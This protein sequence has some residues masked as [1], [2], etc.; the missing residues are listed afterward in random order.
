MLDL[1]GG[2]V[3]LVQILQPDWD[4]DTLRAVRESLASGITVILKR[5][6]NGAST[7]H[8]A[9]REQAQLRMSQDGQTHVLAA[10]AWDAALAGVAPDIAAQFEAG[11]RRAGCFYLVLR[12]PTGA[13]IDQIAYAAGQ[14]RLGQ[15]EPAN[16]SLF[17]TDVDTC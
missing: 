13:F 17:P 11:C 9:A 12:T 2:Y 8:L 14:S 16:G 10:P 6:A 5:D 15:I 3:P 7:L 1:P 4:I